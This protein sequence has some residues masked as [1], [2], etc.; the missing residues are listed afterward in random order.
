MTPIESY[1]PNGFLS[2]DALSTRT[3]SI[4]IHIM[5]LQRGH[6]LFALT[7][8]F[9]RVTYSADLIKTDDI[10]APIDLEVFPIC[11]RIHIEPVIE[12]GVM[13]DEENQTTFSQGFRTS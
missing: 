7:C 8:N 13:V 6:K 11:C 9:G 1:S 2:E 10:H 5:T 3:L 4:S 12:H